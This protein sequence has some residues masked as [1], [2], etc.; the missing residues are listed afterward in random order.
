VNEALGTLRI[1]ETCQKS[2]HSIKTKFCASLNLITETVKKV[3]GVGV[4][5]AAFKRYG[6]RNRPP[7][8]RDLRKCSTTKAQENGTEERSGRLRNLGFVPG[9]ERN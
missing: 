7:R 9:I 8:A 1:A 6:N 2:A 5:Q 4:A 3:N